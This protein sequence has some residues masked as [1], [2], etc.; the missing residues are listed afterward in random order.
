MSEAIATALN[1]I[2]RLGL[3]TFIAIWPIRALLSAW[4]DRRVTGW[5]F[6]LLLVIVLGAMG[7]SVALISTPLFPIPLLILLIL[8]WM[9]T[10][11]E[12]HAQRA[13]ERAMIDEDMQKANEILAQDELNPQAHVVLGRSYH[14]LHRLHDAIAEYEAA[15]R[16][17]PNLPGEK[18]K[19][20][21][22]QQ[23][24][25]EL[26]GERRRCPQCGAMTYK[27]LPVCQHCAYE[28]RA[29]T[30]GMVEDLR[31]G[32]LLAILQWVATAIVIVLA[33]HTLYQVSTLLWGVVMTAALLALA[34][35]VVLFWMRG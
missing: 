6:V 28:P 17:S 16:I 29:L 3:A 19:L 8:W 30:G 11:V 23:E 2:P 26:E 14:K 33:L 27:R 4:S 1:F 18:S 25:E 5:E 15:L 31:T 20:I 10:R 13:I 7:F 35:Y 34:G 21:M 32:G 24:R 22:L 9:G 12:K